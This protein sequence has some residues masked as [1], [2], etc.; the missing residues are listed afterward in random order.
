MTVQGGVDI[1]RF[2]DMGN[3][4]INLLRLDVPVASQPKWD[5]RE[6]LEIMSQQR[7]GA[8]WARVV[9][10]LYGLDGAGP[11]TLEKTGAVFGVTRERIRVLRNKA[12]KYLRGR[13]E[14]RDCLDPARYDLLSALEEVGGLATVEF[15]AER[16]CRG[17]GLDGSTAKGVTRFLLDFNEFHRYGGMWAATPDA[18]LRSVVDALRRISRPAHIKEVAHVVHSD[19]TAGR[20]PSPGYVCDILKGH[21]ELFIREGRGRYGLKEWDRSPD[22]TMA[23]M[24]E[25]VLETGQAQTFLVAGEED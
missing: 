8:R 14:C 24:P 2:Q 20:L 3:P 18:A 9:R 10:I 6:A 11:Q 21:S 17:S 23:G 22:G 15:L 25:P 13:R 16:L 12:L 4:D 19:F 5:V 7:F 1:K